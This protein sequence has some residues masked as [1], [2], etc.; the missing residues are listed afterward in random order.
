MDGICAIINKLDL[1]VKGGVF[2][3]DT[4]F[5]CRIGCVRSI[6]LPDVRI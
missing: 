1:I 6:P 5:M 4:F 3:T 2:E